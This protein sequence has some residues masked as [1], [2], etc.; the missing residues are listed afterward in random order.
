[1]DLDLDMADIQGYRSALTFVALAWLWSANAVHS[2]THWLRALRGENLVND[3]VTDQAGNTYVLGDFRGDLVMHQEFEDVFEDVYVHSS[4]ST[5]IFLLKLDPAGNHV[6]LRRAGGTLK[7][8]GMSVAVSENGTVAVSGNFVGIADIFGISL[9]SANASAD[10]FVALLDADDGTALWA[11]RFG[12]GEGTDR[13]LGVS[14]A[15]NGEVAVVGEFI[16]V[17]NWDVSYLTSMIN[18]LSMTSSTDAFVASYTATGQL[19]WVRQGA[20]EYTDRGVSVTHGPGNEVYALGQFS[21]TITF[22]QTHN[23]PYFS[24]IFLIRYSTT[25]TEEWFCSAGGGPTD[26]GYEVI[27]TPQGDLAIC[28]GMGSSMI[29]SGTSQQLLT[30]AGSRAAFVWRVTIDGTLSQYAA[31]PSYSNVAAKS[32]ALQGDTL[33]IYG[34]FKCQF[35]GLADHYSGSGLF[36]ATGDVDLFIARLT[37]SSLDL[38]DAQQFAGPSAKHANGISFLPDGHLTFGGS[39]PQWLTVP[40]SP[41]WNTEEQNLDTLGL[42]WPPGALLYPFSYCADSFYTAYGIWNAPI[43]GEAHA[44]VGKGYDRTREPLDVWRRWDTIPSC[45]R[46]GVMDSIN[47]RVLYRPPYVVQPVQNL[48]SFSGCSVQLLMDNIF[49]HSEPRIYATSSSIHP[50]L[51][52]PYEYPFSDWV[53]WTLSSDNGC[54]TWETDSVFVSILAPP[55]I[56]LISDGL[57]VNEANEEPDPVLG[58]D[59]FWVWVTNPPVGGTVVWE[60]DSAIVLSTSDSVLIEYPFY[61]TLTVTYTT[62]DSCA[63][64]NEVFVGIRSPMP[65]ITDHE[66]TLFLGL[67]TLYQD[68]VHSCYDQYGL[69]ALLVWY[70]DGMQAD[71]PPDLDML[72]D[73]IVGSD[74]MSRVLH[75]TPIGWINSIPVVA[76]EWS[77]FTVHVTLTNY[78]C[79][80]DDIVVQ[81]SDSLF[82]LPSEIPPYNIEIPEALCQYEPGIVLIN[83]ALCDSLG[84]FGVGVDSISVNADTVWIHGPGTYTLLVYSIGG[85]V[86]C[87]EVVQYIIEGPDPYA[88]LELSPYDGLF[89]PGASMEISTSEPAATYT[90]SGPAGVLLETGPVLTATIPGDYSVSL[91][92]NRGC[93]SELGP[94]SINHVAPPSLEV[95]PQAALCPGEEVTIHVIAGL[96]NAVTW[97]SPLSGSATSQVVFQGGVYSCDITQCGSVYQTSVAIYQGGASA[98]FIDPGPFTICPGDSVLLIATPGQAGYFWP[99]LNSGEPAVW[100]TE[101]G[102][103]QLFAYDAF[104]CV[105]SASTTL[106]YPFDSVLIATGATL[107][108]GGSVTLNATG[109]GTID[110]YADPGLIQ[111]VHSGH[112]YSVSPT[113]TT[114]YY[115]VQSSDGCTTP[116]QSVLV[117]VFPALGE[118]SVTGPASACLGEQVTLSVA[119]PAPGTALWI[120]PNGTSATSATALLDPVTENDA[121]LYEVRVALGNCGRD[122]LFHTLMVFAPTLL[123]LGPDTVLCNGEALALQLPTD[124]SDVVWNS[125][126]NSNLIMVQQ[127]GTYTATASD[128]NGCDVAVTVVVGFISCEGE[129][130]IV[131]IPNVITPNGDGVNDTWNYPAP[132]KSKVHIRILNR[133]GEGLYDVESFNVRWDGRTNSGLKVPDGTYF[134]IAE[135]TS[136]QGGTTQKSGYITVLGNGSQ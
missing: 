38:V 82:M 123:D 59:P 97:G 4:G 90:W 3:I 57:M 91:V 26:R 80:G 33:A 106:Q 132:N 46:Q 1:M 88:Y 63:A 133:W 39:F 52:Q 50:D 20:A 41:L 108:A 98:S 10:G 8:Q 53:Q 72:V 29:F 85:D 128:L 120:R 43:E 17:A 109:S 84:F 136:G 5:D 27:Y 86:A 49:Q 64:S 7:D 95:F 54:W 125:G 93:V 111:L 114:I 62:A 107:C 94:V 44:F 110:W 31:I 117:T 79:T 45:D 21:D 119:I 15:P 104:G 83:C 13:G 24:A 35:Q 73:L 129:G 22:D 69:T 92:D 99:S 65:N 127:P 6:W 77:H 102:P 81:V 61:E 40:I 48:D 25:G 28:G 16:G 60:N 2:Q 12:G 34:E 130:P 47:M 42:V 101:V 18:P 87:T 55:D 131:V 135:I 75:D 66:L 122:T 103:V 113:E 23:N 134:Y 71:P 89:C 56:P 112:S 76:G 74:T 100:V 115:L 9:E 118:L 30:A 58:C 105:D 78:N 14:I 126:Q 67:D 37:Y 121:G 19:Q 96:L 70:I 51:V 68:T 124:L 11:E 36:M 116:P 32:L